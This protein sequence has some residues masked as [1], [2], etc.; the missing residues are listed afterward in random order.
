[1]TP[2]HTRARELALAGI[3]VFPVG[4][5]KRP[6]TAHGFLDRT[7]DLTQIDTWWSQAGYNLAIVPADQSV[8]VF[9]IDGPEGARN[10]SDLCGQNGTPDETKMVG[11]PSG[12]WHLYFKGALPK[13]EGRVAKKIDVRSEDSYVLVP[14]SVGANGK[15]YYDA[16]IGTEPAPLLP[17]QIARAQVSK[18][19]KKM[20]LEGVELDREPDVDRG[21]E[22]IRLHKK[23]HGEPVE[24]Q[25]SDGLT[26]SLA[27]WLADGPLSDTMI[28][29]LLS[30]YWSPNFDIEWLELKVSNADR[31]RTNDR[32]IERVQTGSE[33][34][35]HVTIPKGRFHRWTASDLINMPPVAF[36]D[37]DKMFPKVDTDGTVGVLYGPSGHHKTNVL[38]AKLF[39]INDCRIA[40][41][42]GEGRPGFGQRLGAHCRVRGINPDDM[43]ERWCFSTVPLVGQEND[44]AAFQEFLKQ[45]EFRPNI[46]IL[47]TWRTA[48][49]G[50]DDDTRTA[51]LLT[52]NGAVGQLAAEYAATIVIVGHTGKDDS[53]GMNGTKAYHDNVDFKLRC[54]ANKDT[55]ADAVEIK[56]EK[57]RD[58]SSG[59]SSFYEIAHVG[60]VPVPQAIS[61]AAYDVLVG[62]DKVFT[63]DKVRGALLG[64]QAHD[65]EHAV[66]STVLVRS[67]C[68]IGRGQ[69]IEDWERSVARMT[70]KLER[71]APELPQC[72]D[73]LWFSASRP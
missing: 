4:A 47:D 21:V 59:H 65:K 17:W 25:S 72:Q 62:S 12:G 63:E 11:T 54:L 60:G 37:K 46:I 33:V 9:D 19:E 1:M 41:A 18:R 43:D 61:A 39:G 28:V 55:R 14:P 5:D 71:L 34:F 7:T 57:M 40:Y 68:P 27:N 51:A 66:S 53:R 49:A 29:E 31:Y 36:W 45:Q 70:R 42:L 50:L 26:L 16:T 38:L 73:S 52:A 13:S 44:L 32:A 22:K 64:L 10:W 58:G 6:V 48:T 20:A 67:L 30:R 2:L 23:N 56:C 35:A 8:S 3:P 24:G 15:P 69:D